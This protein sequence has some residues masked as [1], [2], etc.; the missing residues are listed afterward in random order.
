MKFIFTLLFVALSLFGSGQVSWDVEVGGGGIGNPSP[1]YSPQFF[2]IAVGDTVRW[3]RVQGSHNVDGRISTFPSNLEDFFSGQPANSWMEFEHV[4][5]LAGVYDYECG[6]EGHADTQFGTITVESVPTGIEENTIV[7]F[8][9]YPNPVEDELNILT[10]SPLTEIQIL[11]V[12]RNISLTIEPSAENGVHVVNTSV[13]SS[14]IYFV[15]VH[16]H[17]NKGVRRFIKR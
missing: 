2:T 6:Q 12:S 1:Y 8:Y 14:G 15:I 10:E 16:T 5:T 13:L 3:N 17:E 9:I 7:D 11:D 4:F